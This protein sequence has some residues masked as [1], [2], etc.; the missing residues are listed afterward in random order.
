M[1]ALEV[2]GD[3]AVVV[4]A[5]DG[6]PM[7]RKSDMSPPMSF[8]SHL[9]RSN[10]L[11]TI[12][13]VATVLLMT[14]VASTAQ[15]GPKGFKSPEDAAQALLAAAKSA[16]DTDL[17]QIL[18]PS[19]KEW[20]RSGDPVADAQARTNFVT[21]AE[22]K[23]AFEQEGAGKVVALIGDD[24]FPFPI[25]LVKSGEEWKFDPESGKQEII[26]RRVGSNELTTIQT[27]LAIVDA[28]NDYA[29]LSRSRGHSAEY[30]RKFISSSGKQDGLYWPTE[31]GQP[32]SPLGELVANAE[33]AGYS[34]RAASEPRVPFN[35]YYYR[36]L[37]AQGPAAKGGSYDYLVRGKLLGGF[38]V[39]AWPARYGVSGYKT[40]MTNH[41]G[42]VYEADLGPKTDRIVGRTQAF[43]PGPTWKPVTP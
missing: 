35:G 36:M 14:A 41:D 4:D 42:I 22:Q 15:T 21:A 26:D 30:A 3:V 19:L 28:Q 27:L 25:P 32:K 12:A 18:G 2:A 17:T 9:L 39:I 1:V 11:A 31:E 34:A 16:D 7:S 5:A 20:I 8:H 24:A 37:F 29:A 43:N 23:L 40:F 38:A 6:D 33:G 13:L 10:S